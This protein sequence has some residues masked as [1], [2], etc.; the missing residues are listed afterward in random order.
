MIQKKIDRIIKEISLRN[1]I[2]VVE[3]EEI[4]KSQFA[5]VKQIIEEG[6][7]DKEETFKTVLLPHFGKF[8]VKRDKINHIIK[9]KNGARSK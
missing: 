3:V 1:N 7:R 9:K 8:L 2:P 6:E 5:F 4:I